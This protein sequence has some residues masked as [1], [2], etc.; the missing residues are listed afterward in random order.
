MSTSLERVKTTDLYGNKDI[1]FA[2]TSR[3]DM[4]SSIQLHF[5]TEKT[6]LC[7]LEYHLPYVYPVTNVVYTRAQAVSMNNAELS[8]A[9]SIPAIH[10]LSDIDAPGS[11]DVT[12]IICGLARHSLAS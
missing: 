4:N 12:I 11:A 7:H 6:Q 9:D 3:Q 5:I 1:K 10:S 2:M 8:V